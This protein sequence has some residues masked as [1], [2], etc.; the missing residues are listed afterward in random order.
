MTEGEKLAFY[1]L[2]H[3]CCE[4]SWNRDAPGVVCLP[5]QGLLCGHTCG[6]VEVRCEHILKLAYRC[7]LEERHLQVMTQVGQSPP[8][9]QEK[10]HKHTQTCGNQ[11]PPIVLA[12]WWITYR[13]VNVAVISDVTFV[14]IML[15][16][17][18]SIMLHLCVLC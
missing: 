16:L 18:T 11:K 3:R 1:R 13:Y 10:R 8:E 15:M 5:S 4:K 6:T 2:S 14:C 17:L 12:L 9:S 7:T